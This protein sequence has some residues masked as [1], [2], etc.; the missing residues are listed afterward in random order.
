MELLWHY[1]ITIALYY[2]LYALDR[3]PVEK[4]VAFRS[5]FL[6]LATK[7]SFKILIYASWIIVL[8]IKYN[9]STPPEL[10]YPQTITEPPPC[11]LLWESNYSDSLFACL[12]TVRFPSDPKRLNLLSF[13]HITRFQKLWS[14]SWYFWA[15]CTRFSRL[16]LF[17]QNFFRITRSL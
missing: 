5:S 7:F 8:S 2:K 17:T 6:A 3:C 1:I 4:C 16:I 10:I 15:N 13:D 14:L 9:C 12:H 11:V